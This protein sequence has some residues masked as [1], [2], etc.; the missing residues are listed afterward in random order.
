MP[1]LSI[2]RRDVL[3]N[4]PHPQDVNSGNPGGAMAGFDDGIPSRFPNFLLRS[5]QGCSIV[6]RSFEEFDDDQNYL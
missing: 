6:V 5:D 3:I 2:A 4:H 1:N